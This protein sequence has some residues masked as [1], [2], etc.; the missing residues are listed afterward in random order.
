MPVP[1][2]I[3]DPAVQALHRARAVRLQADRFLVQEAQDGIK[4]RLATVKRDFASALA[5][6]G[7]ATAVLPG[8]A[9]QTGTFDGG[10]R[11]AANGVFDLVVSILTL[12]GLNDLPGA[13]AQI[14]RTLK[15]DGLFVGALFGGVTL[16]E[17]RDSL[18]AAELAT[19]GGVSPRVA[20]M[21]D[22]RD[23]GGLMQRAGF[24]LPV[25]DVERTTAR[26][27][28]VFGLVRDLRAMGETNALVARLGR[29]RRDTLAAA[30]RHYQ[31]NHADADGRLCATFDIVY[32]TGWAPASLG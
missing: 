5:L 28:D 25:A 23:L 6:D 1:P 7:D 11:L 31:M 18:A 19:T 12:H 32:L 20:P 9:W 10:E 16:A 21:A 14:R 8:A 17:L 29:L 2:R 22:V 15:P 26:Y 13:L 27:R 30:I 3:F 24:A 4:D